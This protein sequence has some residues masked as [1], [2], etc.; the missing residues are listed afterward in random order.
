MNIWK[1]EKISEAFIITGRGT[2]ITFFPFENNIRFT[3]VYPFKCGDKF[4]YNDVEYDIIGIEFIP[5]YKN[6]QYQLFGFLIKEELS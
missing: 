1:L 4:I 3:D 2:L 5:T 6:N